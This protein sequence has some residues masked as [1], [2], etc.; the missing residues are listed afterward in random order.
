MTR[1]R[2]RRGDAAEQIEQQE[3]GVPQAILDVVAEDP[4]VEHVPDEVQPAAVQEHRRQHSQ[5]S[6]L[7]RY[8]AVQIHERLERSIAEGE[9]EDEYRAV[10]NDERDREEGECSRRDDVAQRNHGG[11]CA[12][13]GC[14]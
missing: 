13:L 7:G 11:D 8:D 2:E 1:L 10:E 3:A 12:I 9:L 6:E 4:E 5:P 14:A